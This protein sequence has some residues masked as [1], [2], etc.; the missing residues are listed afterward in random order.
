MKRILT[1]L[2]IVQIFLLLFLPGIVHAQTTVTGV[3]KDGTTGEALP[4]VNIIVQGTETGTTTDIEGR[5]SLQVPDPNS[6]LAF[7]FVGYLSETYNLNGATRV[8]LTLTQDVLS[9]EEL[10]VVGYGA[11]RK[12]DLTGSVSVV[13]AA[14]LERIEANDISKLLQ[15]QAAGV[16]VSGSGQPGARPKVKIRGPGSFGNTEPLYVVDGVPIANATLVDVGLF[17]GQNDQASGGISDLNPDDIESIQILKDASAAAIYG[18]RGANG[19]VIITTKRGKSGDMRVT[20]EGS[21]GFQD[22]TKRMEVCNREQFQEMNTVARLNA[23]QFIAPANDPTDP[24]YIDDIN[25]DWQEEVFKTGHITDHILTFSGGSEQ[26][27][28]YAS[29]NYFDQTGTMT[30]PGPRY[31]RYSAKLNMDQTRGRFKFGESFYYGYSDQIRLTN[32]QWANPI[33]E[34]VMALPTVPVYDSNNI[35]G[36]GGGIDEIHDQIAGNQVAFNS[37]KNNYLKR[38]RFQGIL[39]GELEIISGLKYRLNLSYD[40][41]DWLNHEFYPVFEIG[42]RH[43]NPIAFLNEWRGENPYMLMEQTLT[44]SRIFGKHNLTALAGHSVQYDYFAQNYA[45]SEGFTEPYLEVISAGPDNQ[46]A[47]GDLYEHRMLSYFGR[48]NYTYDDRYL[49]TFNMRRDYSSRF[50]PNNKYGDFPSFSAAWKVHNEAFFNVEFISML[51]LRAGYGKIGNDN[52]GDYL[53]ESYINNAVTY[54]FGGQLPSAGIQT[55]I[56][57][58]SIKW[59]ERITSNAGVDMAFFN[60]KLEFSVEYY[61]NNAKDILYAVPVPW[62]TGTVAN[63][64]V[65]SASMINKGWEFVLGYRQMEGDF[66]Y[67]INANLA[68]LKNEVTALGTQDE[69]VLRYMSRT[70]VGHSMGE[71]YGWEMEG[72][73]QN[74]AEIDSH[75]FQNNARPGDIMFRDINEDDRITDE[76]RVYMGSAFPTLT[77]GMNISLEYKGF[78]LSIFLSGV[79]GNMIYNGTKVV[80]NEMK[81]GNYSVESYENYWRGEGTS[82]EYPRP[83]VLDRNQNARMSQRWLEDGSY[84]RLQNIQLGYSL[85]KNIVNRIPGVEGLRVYVTAQNLYT[86]TK[87]TGFDPDITNDGLFLRGEDWGSYPSPRTINGGIKITL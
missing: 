23:N 34:T 48:L 73:F 63:P 11:T 36:F 24:L 65:N 46:T 32:S 52:I 30:G 49:A 7:S 56:V 57:D 68:T 62:S 6:V 19:V 26:S 38:Y 61:H 28:Y 59:E 79:Y 54:V 31:T 60:N 77:G 5:F 71:L 87:Y 3:V 25:T 85:P 66:H 51:K 15:G 10:V 13:S 74:Q 44:Y 33:Y 75:A 82:T 20:Y 12:Q 84:L 39:Y 58:P 21:Y 14:D 37:I 4:G 40:R 16:Q 86:L 50:G 17:E 80:L 70:A 18:A 69:P 1:K 43:T 45:H 81:Y 78:D 35:G 22:I 29:I 41:S 27:T 72:I 9:L 2:C 83:T 55:N 8:D 67:Y 42:S 47:L 64:T 53:Y 76:D